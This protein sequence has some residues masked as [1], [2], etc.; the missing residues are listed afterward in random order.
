[1]GVNL[2]LIVSILRIDVIDCICP[3]ALDYSKLYLIDLVC[4]F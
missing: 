1:M 3:Y 4:I 2:H